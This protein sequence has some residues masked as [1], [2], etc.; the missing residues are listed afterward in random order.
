MLHLNATPAHPA[1]FLQ[2]YNEQLRDLLVADSPDLDLREDGNGNSVV[3]GVYRPAIQSPKGLYKLLK[4]GNKRRTAEAT[5]ANKA[6]S[7]SHAVLEV[8]VERENTTPGIKQ[9]I[10]TGRLFMI[11]LAGSERAANAM[12]NG[13]RMVE[14]Q[15][16]NRS[17]LALGN[18]INSLGG[19]TRSKYVNYRDSKLT[20]LLKDSLSGNCRTVMIACAS[21]ASNH[22]EETYNTMNY[23][24]RAKNIKTTIAKNVSTVEAH[25]SEYVTIISG[26][27]SQ[28]TSLKLKLELGDEGDEAIGDDEGVER[29][30]DAWLSNINTAYAQQKMAQEKLLALGIEA[31]PSAAS[32]GHAAVPSGR[33]SSASFNTMEERR[34]ALQTELSELTAATERL[35]DFASTTLDSKDRRVLDSLRQA[36]DMEFKVLK[37]HYASKA[38][39]Q[40][41]LDMLLVAQQFWQSMDLRDQIIE[42]QRGIMQQE[43]V[44]TPP[45]LQSL[46]DQLDLLRAQEQ[47]PPKALPEIERTPSPG[48]F[49]GVGSSNNQ[50]STLVPE[51]MPPLSP[52][53][54]VPSR[55]ASLETNGVVPPRSS[56]GVAVPPAPKRGQKL[57]RLSAPVAL[58]T[59]QAHSPPPATIATTSAH[60]RK[61]VVA[62]PKSPADISSSSNP[63]QR[64]VVGA[65]SFPTSAHAHAAVA[66]QHTPQT[67][68]P[69]VSSIASTGN[70]K[71]T[72]KPKPLA[73]KTTTII[74]S[75][76]SRTITTTDNTLKD[77]MR[78]KIS[79]SAARSRAP[80][81]A[82]SAGTAGTA[83]VVSPPRRISVGSATSTR[84]VH[85][86]C[87]SATSTTPIAREKTT[88]S[89]TSSS[90]F[91]D[92]AST[93]GVLPP[94]SRQATATSFT[95]T[96]GSNPLNGT[97]TKDEFDDALSA[98][99]EIARTASQSTTPITGAT[100][101]PV[102]PD[103]R[104]KQAVA[105]S[106]TTS[107]RPKASS[108]T[109]TA[110]KPVSKTR[111]SPT[112][113]NKGRSKISSPYGQGS[114][115]SHPT[116]TSRASP[117]RA[118]GA[119]SNTGTSGASL[120]PKP[121]PSKSSSRGPTP[122][123]GGV[124]NGSPSPQPAVSSKKLSPELGVRGR[125]PSPRRAPDENT[126]ADATAR[127]PS[128][129]VPNSSTSSATSRTKSGIEVKVISQI[130]TSPRAKPRGSKT[131][132]NAKGRSPIKGMG[133]GTGL[134][135]LSIQASPYGMPANARQPRGVR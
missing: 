13:A 71:P 23:A 20:R 112:T 58:P 78:S 113:S 53:S 56:L 48:S 111:A 97:Y 42:Q 12:N 7:R 38:A 29:V 64:K 37:A 114:S 83:G 121:A 130:K 21:P 19:P 68:T 49:L 34:A 60:Q 107:L 95:L 39:E 115:A 75:A 52:I 128:P 94:L 28:V 45:E 122:A 54:R 118:N 72:P 99:K 69:Q 132:R 85:V 1:C 18:C 57:P 117:T 100:K 120:S 55:R 61:A 3:C 26:L 102:S 50:Q 70:P 104:A 40:K 47:S 103:M 2:I 86:T 46:Y 59:P 92:G 22:F 4:Q 119:G 126:T 106:L 82:Q 131:R 123:A 109:N 9:T 16:I 110:A 41:A 89:I 91:E 11:D 14:G 27:R 105:S 33:D 17:L 116:K 81:S 96:R 63:H 129:S 66:P 125:S 32:G 25:V 77:V 127:A 35:M 44:Q 43:G 31:T 84:T 87:G 80:P 10:Q 15:H 135:D 36:Q 108:N 98:E 24:N 93:V 76:G 133:G 134:F 124:T 30:P 8:Q 51:K 67:V 90:L 88:L 79:P 65:T 73:T 101:S 62:G 74:S 5:S 6:S